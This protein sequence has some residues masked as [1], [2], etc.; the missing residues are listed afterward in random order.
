MVLVYSLCS[1]FA[2]SDFCLKLLFKFLSVLWLCWVFVAPRWLS[3]VVLS[4]G[5]SS[6]G[7]QASLAALHG[8]RAH[9]LFLLRST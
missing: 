8:S 5:Y 9:R 3:R 7:C 2:H 6:S 1:N 4:G